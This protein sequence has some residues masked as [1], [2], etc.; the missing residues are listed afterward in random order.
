[1]RKGYL[2]LSESTPFW[3]FSCN[4]C[5]I[6]CYVTF[7]RKKKAILWEYIKNL[8]CHKIAHDFKKFAKHFQQHLACIK[9]ECCVTMFHLQVSNILG[10]LKLI[11]TT[12]SIMNLMA[13]QHIIK[14]NFETITHSNLTRACIQVAYH[15]HIECQH[16][17]IDITLLGQW[18]IKWTSKTAPYCSLIH[19][20]VF[21]K[22]YK[23]HL[24][25]PMSRP[26]S[27][28]GTMAS[29]ISL[30]FIIFLSIL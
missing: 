16:L 12:N 18:A 6:L 14:N 3:C 5:T 27:P 28:C 1:M 17:N 19:T 4:I 24:G 8:I 15:S 7:W 2:H 9:T 23:W 20:H 22:C 11:H 10:K 30:V 13:R 29:Q 21:I 25:I 26:L